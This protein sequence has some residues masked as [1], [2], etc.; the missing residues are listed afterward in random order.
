[1]EQVTS[2]LAVIKMGH[3]LIKDEISCGMETISFSEGI[4]KLSQSRIT[5]YHFF[6][7]KKSQLKY[8]FVWERP[9]N[10]LQNS[11]MLLLS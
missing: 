3:I 7:H 9:R 5:R 4:C 2:M 8:N 10:H 1:M 11:F 6:L